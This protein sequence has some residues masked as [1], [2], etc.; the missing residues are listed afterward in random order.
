MMSKYDTQLVSTKTKAK[1]RVHDII[2]LAK[3]GKKI[4]LIKEYRSF[5]GLGL[6]DSK[7][8]IEEYQKT[9]SQSNGLIPATY[10]IDGL[11]YEFEKLSQNITISK[12]EF[13]QIIDDAIEAQDKFYYTDMLDVVETLCNNIRNYGGLRKIAM[14][15]DQFLEGI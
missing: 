6:K 10:D 14:E 11:V 13:I 12:E 2:E 5:S 3:E 7:D 8:L 15:R 4:A 1:I 9:E